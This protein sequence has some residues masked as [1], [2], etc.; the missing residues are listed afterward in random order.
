MRQ[1]ARRRRAAL[2]VR[3]A[4]QR[5]AALQRDRPLR[6]SQRGRRPLRG[7]RRDPIVR[8]RPRVRAGGSDLLGREE[9]YGPGA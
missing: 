1:H 4:R 7:R 2:G 5:T 3:C 8:L 9:R 6:R